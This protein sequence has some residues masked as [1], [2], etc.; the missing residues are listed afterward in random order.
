VEPAYDRTLPRRAR[1]AAGSY[2][3]PRWLVDEVVA[4][5]L[6]P[7][8]A[9]GVAW[10]RVLDPAC[11]DGRFLASAAAL[12]AARR[13]VT[14]AA[15]ARRC[16]VGVERDARAAA[17]ARAAVPGADVRVGDALLGDAIDE[18]FDAVVGNPPWVR[19]VTLRRADPKT[20]RALRGR[21]VATSYREWDLYAAFLERALDWGAEAG[22]VTPS[23]WLTAQF[24]GPLRAALAGR[25]RRVV[26]F[27]ARQLFE[28]AT[29]YTAVVHLS[30]AG[31]DAVEVERGG[32][33]GRIPSAR[34]GAAPW[35]LEIGAPARLLARLERGC[36]PLGEIARVA[37][38]A[39]TNADPIFLLAP[40]APLEHLV[41]CLRGR[42]VKPWQA[43]VARHALLPY[44]DGRLLAPEKLERRARAW[45]EEHRAAL[46]RRERGRFAGPTFY[47]WGRPQNLLWHLDPAPK[48]VV[49]DAASEGR[50]ALDD[51]GTL[52]IDTA[53][54]IR[55]TG[56]YPIA[57]LLAILNS[58]V[59]GEWLRATGIPLRG[60][61][62]RM[63]TAYLNSLPVP[64]PT[65]PAAR[66]AA[67]AGRDAN[68]LALYGL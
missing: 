41:P 57:L 42:D 47:Q 39:G 14:A 61:Y 20:W 28:D 6:A 3:T 30:R 55:P 66:A 13:G 64:D 51:R 17:A 15:A 40:G 68:V 18:D 24:A 21:F 12:I 4:E 33:R 26:D 32:A 8:L 46:E 65:T 36:R 63:K 27:G 58:P 56:D 23:R 34:L 37:K 1:R 52:P 35:R 43:T 29:T 67:A 5:T 22:L 59:V 16:M 60:G 31:A 38:G 48:I 10:P 62:F 11:G 54:A 45:L 53:Y 25:V 2:Y 50:A 44:R 7:V 9:R 19:S 49:P